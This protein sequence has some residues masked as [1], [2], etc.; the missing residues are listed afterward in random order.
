MGSEP[1]MRT[2]A[3]LWP[4]LKAVALND[5]HIDR[6][7]GTPRCVAQMREGPQF[8]LY[9]IVQTDAVAQAGDELIIDGITGRGR[10]AR[11]D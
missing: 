3:K 9:R 11:H 6:I 7:C 8:G 2:A 4:N 1:E 5:G 10:R